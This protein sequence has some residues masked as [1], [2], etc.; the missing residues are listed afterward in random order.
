ML[1]IISHKWK[2]PIKHDLISLDDTMTQDWPEGSEPTAVGIPSPFPILSSEKTALM[3]TEHLQQHE[4][5]LQT[6]LTMIQ[7][8]L[9]NR[10]K[11]INV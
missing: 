11:Q 6:T 1:K 8:E 4:K 2:S 7:T 10:S 5:Q 3:S 9:K